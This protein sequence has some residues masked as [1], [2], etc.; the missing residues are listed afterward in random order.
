MEKL[1]KLVNPTF[2]FDFTSYEETC[3]E[4]NNLNI[5]KIFQKTDI[6]VKIVKENIDIISY[7][8]YHNFKNLLSC[9]T[10][11]PA[12]KYAE[13]TPIHKKDDKIDKENYHPIII[14]P[15]LSKVYE[16]SMYNQIYPYFHTIF[17]SFSSGYRKVL[18]HSIVF[19]NGRK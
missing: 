14:L 3:K 18:M 17:S 10:F 11:P 19:S 9:S 6:P 12:M 4:V 7:F 15:N 1:E 13:V 16:R 8:L 5:R 2:G